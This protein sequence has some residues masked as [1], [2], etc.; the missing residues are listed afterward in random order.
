MY[1]LFNLFM[2]PAFKYYLFANLIKTLIIKSIKKSK[3][4]E[5]YVIKYSKEKKVKKFAKLL[6]S[7]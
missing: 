4:F 5:Q 1:F 7:L 6:L 3:K 2:F